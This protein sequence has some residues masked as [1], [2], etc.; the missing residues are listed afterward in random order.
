M[1]TKRNNN[2]KKRA[3]KQRYYQL[4]GKNIAVITIN[5]ISRYLITA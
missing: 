1:Y 3:P 4:K 2:L 5:G